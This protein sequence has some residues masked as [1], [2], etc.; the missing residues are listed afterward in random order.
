M[1]E[2]GWKMRAEVLGRAYRKTQSGFTLLEIL[3]G[4]VLMSIMMTLLFGSIRMGARVW[5]T[6]EK[7]AASVDRMLIIQNFLRQHLATARPVFDD[8]SSEDSVFSFSGTESS[9]QFVSD[10]PSSARR[11]GIHQFNLEVVKE[12]D[13]NVLYAKLKIFYPPLDGVDAAIEDVRL[14]SE[15]DSMV[16]AYYGLD[17]F[18]VEASDARWMDE[19][20]DRDYMPILIK[21]VI[22]MSDGTYWP[23][24]IV[25][26]KLV[27]IDPDL[28]KTLGEN[29]E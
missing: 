16:V 18:D 17:D 25:S 15:I 2:I 9:L 7:R 12:E 5:D 20:Q 23:P 19:W 14:I 3:I 26:P 1:L 8:F 27:S 29:F 28:L 6:G 13:S 21:I 10:L 11:G 24:I 22:Q 4:M